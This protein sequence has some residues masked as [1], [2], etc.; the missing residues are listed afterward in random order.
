MRGSP[1]TPPPPSISSRDGYSA[2]WS[3]G[4][5]RA[6]HGGGSA[7]LPDDGEQE[8]HPGPATWTSTGS[9]PQAYA[10]PTVLS[11]DHSTLECML[12]VKSDA[13]GWAGL[14]SSCPLFLCLSVALSSAGWRP[15][16]HQS[17]IH[18][19]THKPSRLTPAPVGAGFREGSGTVTHAQ[20]CQGRAWGG[21]LPRWQLRGMFCRRFGRVKVPNS[22]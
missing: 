13:P 3:A 4:K 17:Y 19:H 1:P 5:G 20:R 18:T 14:Q 7:G 15:R 22:S 21:G 2:S 9:R 16:P 6:G 11:L 10:L 12:Q 8:K